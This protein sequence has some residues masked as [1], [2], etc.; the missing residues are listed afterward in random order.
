MWNGDTSLP[1]H[2]HADSTPLLQ[3]HPRSST[4]TTTLL[5]IWTVF[6]WCDRASG[7]KP[8]DLRFY[9]ADRL[10]VKRDADS[11]R[12]DMRFTLEFFLL[13]THTAVTVFYCHADQFPPPINFWN[14]WLDPFTV[15]LSWTKPSSL[16]DDH[17]IFFFLKGDPED[18]ST[19]VKG[20]LRNYRV[21]ENFLTEENIS[22][23]WT[24]NIWTVKDCEHLHS[25]KPANT[26][27]STW[28]PRAQ[29]VKDFKCVVY[30]EVMKC[31]WI[32]VNRSLSLTLFYRFCGSLEESI[33]SLKTCDEPY[34]VGERSCCDLH[35]NYSVEDVCV[36]VETEAAMSTF[37][38]RLSVPPPKLTIR[39]V[40]DYL[41]VSAT[42]PEVGEKACWTYEVCHKPC[43]KTKVCQNTSIG[44]PTIK[45]PYDKNCL[46]E[47]QSK[48]RM[49]KYCSRLNSNFS[50]TVTHGVN[51]PPDLTLTAVSIAV[52]LI[53]SICVIL[54]CCSYRRRG[55]I[56][57]V[58]P[59]PSAI[60]EEMMN[61][62][63]E[64][65]V[66]GSLYTPVPERIEACKI[67]LESENS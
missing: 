2:F 31:S 6:P 14:E 63:K 58:I 4:V 16:P 57:P 36:L 42:P 23:D 62:S 59:D 53:L 47:F 22:K 44:E 39:E 66:T 52:P 29:L 43:S 25:S 9:P 37:I 67:S 61:G 48:A 45:V 21:S 17:E 33:K 51:K 55:V 65:K 40:G 38:A 10:E 3:R 18:K 8:R 20:S 60:F 49:S 35:L 30:S 13:L 1:S 5:F 7:Q 26:I 12:G 50:E 27:I 41:T 64:L 15:M 56:F 34:I 11:P 46:Y 19:C 54:C 32:P 28:K 24:Y